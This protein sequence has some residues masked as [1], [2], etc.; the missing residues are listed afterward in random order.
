LI[1]QVKKYNDIKFEFLLKKY[2]CVDMGYIFQI[3]NLR[4]VSLFCLLLSLTLMWSYV[5]RHLRFLSLTYSDLSGDKY[6][7]IFLF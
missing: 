4:Q 1:D 2:A 5:C 6:H 7:K 3:P